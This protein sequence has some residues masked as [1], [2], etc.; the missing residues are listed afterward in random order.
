MINRK[1][2][3]VILMLAAACL[4]L[5]AC[6]NNAQ[7]AQPAPT[8]TAAPSTMSGATNS[9]GQMNGTDTARDPSAAGNT[10]ASA[11]G[12]LA[13]FD[14]A[15]GAANVE[16]AIG[17]ISELSEARVV[18]ADTTALVGVRF[19]GAYKGELTERIREMVAGE[20]LKVDPAIQTVAV[21]ANSEDVA[22]IYDISDRIRAGRTAAELAP[23][24]NSIVRNATTLR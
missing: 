5:A 17:R 6:M 23:E 19:D 9:P 21:T 3:P 12:A 14:W 24:I 10:G 4:A 11:G 20:V 22:K 16:K 8:A 2:I 7:P 1:I 13:P 15:N 18:V